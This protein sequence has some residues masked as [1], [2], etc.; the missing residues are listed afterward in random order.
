MGIVFR[1]SAKNAIVTATGAVLGALI[2]A[3]SVKFIARQHYGFIGNF[4]NY[5]VTISQL[6]LFGINYTLVVYIHRYNHDERKRRALL[7]WSFLLPGVLAVIG[8]VV[9]LSL[10]TWILNHFQPADQPLMDRYFIWLPVF[11]VMFIYLMLFESYL[12]TQMK[13]AVA[14][15]MREVVLRVVNIALILL[16]A[17]GYVNFDVLVIG[18]VLIYVV[19]VVILALLAMRTDNFRFSLRL[20]DLSRAE[21]NDLLKFTW[22]HFLL[23]AS[24]NLIASLDAM[25]LPLYDHKGFEVVAVFRVAVFLIS[26]LQIPTKAMTT[27]SFTVLAKAFAE[28][29]HIKA[30]D[31]F[32]RSSINIFIATVAVALVLCC[33]LPGLVAVVGKG[34]ADVAPV[35]LI[36][37]AGQ[38]VNI[39]TGMND[40]VLSITNYYKFNF[41]LSLILM[42][43]LFLLIRFLVPQF[44]IFG[45]AWS[46]TITIVVFNAAKCWFVWKKLDMLP[47][48]GRTLRV[49]A[50]ALPAL[51]GGLLLPHFFSQV[52]HIY[53]NTA[54]DAGLRS[55]VI[56]VIYLLM[57]LW[58]KPS[59]DLE[60]YLITIRKNKRLF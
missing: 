1:Q 43:T 14:A 29:D 36:L 10:R 4:T 27:A 35:F 25:L 52:R 15:F 53:I 39:A 9:Y 46:T 50:A 31:L 30:A 42:A 60:E 12:G 34:Y 13:V 57:L 48:S 28:N 3:L 45:A 20:S 7:T 37:F 38:L 24:V 47:F 21:Y 51:A 59:K 11:T 23:T 22:Y 55:F 41:Y 40:Q 32:V 49:V 19:P 18:T 56:V 8:A 6:M 58:L 26:F 16:F 5:A 33:N 54:L 44:G 2:M 17:F